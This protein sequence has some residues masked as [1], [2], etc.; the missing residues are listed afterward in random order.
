MKRARFFVYKASDR[1]AFGRDGRLLLVTRDGTLPQPVVPLCIEQAVLVKS[2]A[3]ELMVDIRRQ[4]EG[5]LA[6][7]KLR[8]IAIRHADG[9]VISVMPYFL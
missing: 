9:A 8:Q 3:A 2:R 5:I 7:Q 1:L 6:F 4:H